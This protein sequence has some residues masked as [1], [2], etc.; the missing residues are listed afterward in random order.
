MSRKHFQELAEIVKNSS[1]LSDTQRAE[2]ARDIAVFC[3]D[4]NN[5]FNRQKFLDAC[6]VD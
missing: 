3:M 2:L 6:E 1:N 5:N 4:H